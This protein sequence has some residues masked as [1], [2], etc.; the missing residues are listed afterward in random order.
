MSEHTPGARMRSLAGTALMGTDR[1]GHTG[2]A[3]GLLSEAAACGTRM[4]AGWKP[5]RVEVS[6]PPCPEDA[7]AA[8]SPGA[9]RILG[10][11]IEANEGW[12]IDEWATLALA[13]GV[14]VHEAML[15]ALLRWW[16][17]QPEQS[18]TVREAMG[19]RGVWLARLNDAWRLVAAAGEQGEG[20]E[21]AW[22][23]GTTMERLAA[24]KAMRRRDPARARALVESTW[25]ADPADARR[26]FLEAMM[27]HRSPDDEPF[28][29][30]ALDD[31]SKQ[32]RQ[33]A[34]TVLR[35]I[36]GSALRQ[37]L[38]RVGRSLIQVETKRGLLKKGVRL[39]VTPPA[40][41]DEAWKR[42]GI[43]EDAM[44]GKGKRASWAVRIL[45][46]TDLAIWTEATGL[47]PDDVVDAIK[48]S[49]DAADILEGMRL[50][51]QVSGGPAWNAALVRATLAR[52]G[53]ERP[54]PHELAGLWASLEPSERETLVLRVV[55]GKDVSID[56]RWMTLGTC[57][58]RWSAWFSKN[59]IIALEGPERK[60]SMPNWLMLD[61]MATVARF[62]SPGEANAFEARVKEACGPEPTPAVRKHIDCVRLRADMHKELAP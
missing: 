53:K 58:A 42:D 11:L 31:K 14:R 7:R 35:H 1:G 36:A 21:A 22:E 49:E 13:K 43:E 24:L 23:T 32:V 15:P 40:T 38:G 19:V 55:T 29:E 16:V 51:A 60:G 4:K 6:I 34:A 26:R 54:A 48:E 44:P 61:A 57:R 59:A 46:C 27:E 3:A 39:T 18:A 37:R 47:D 17:R 50:S 5:A 9:T 20:I 56:E 12:L 41:Y 33:N 62:V 45:A 8:A 25:K 52:T 28:L 2:G 10:D 30:S